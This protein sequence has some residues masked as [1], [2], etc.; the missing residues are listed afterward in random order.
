MSK[1]TQNTSTASL[2]RDARTRAAITALL[3]VAATATTGCATRKAPF[4]QLDQSTV[5]ILRLQQAPQQAQLPQPGGLPL[6]P[7]LHPR[8]ASEYQGPTP[9]RQLEPPGFLALNYGR[10]TPISEEI[11]SPATAGLM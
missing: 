10:P 7:G 2:P 3:V 4:D 8:M 5:T 1:T 9:T 11:S 6:I